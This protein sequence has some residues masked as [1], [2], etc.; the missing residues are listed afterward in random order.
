MP[1][2]ELLMVMAICILGPATAY[3]VVAENFLM[4]SKWQQF[5]VTLWNI[6]ASLGLIFTLYVISS[7][8]GTLEA[9]Y[10]LYRESAGLARFIWSFGPLV[11]FIMSAFLGGFWSFHCVK[12]ALAYSKGAIEYN[13]AMEAFKIDD[14]KK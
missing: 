3:A 13:I 2:K 9:Y 1:S 12:K 5:R 4:L 6:L 7:F 11:Q 14:N 8:T 10:R